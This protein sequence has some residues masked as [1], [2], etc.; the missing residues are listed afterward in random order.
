MKNTT[1]IGVCLQ[2]LKQD[3]RRHDMQM[4]KSD[5]GRQLALAITNIEQGLHWLEIYESNPRFHGVDMK[6][7]VMPTGITPDRDNV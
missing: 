2:E 4:G 6:S 7:E 3:L 1:L 5:A